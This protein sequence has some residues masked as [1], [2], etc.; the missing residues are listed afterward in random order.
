[1]H[2]LIL[3]VVG[4]TWISIPRGENFQIEAAQIKEAIDAQDVKIIFITTP[5]IRR[6]FHLTRV[7]EEIAKGVASRSV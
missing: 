1:M 2:P 5:N 6:N 4:K 7:I 3:R